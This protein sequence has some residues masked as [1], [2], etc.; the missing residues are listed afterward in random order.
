MITK[1]LQDAIESLKI[2]D[3]YLIELISEHKN[4]FNPKDADDLD[5]LEFQHMHVVEK[6]SVLETGNGELLLRVYTRLG[7][8]WI[9]AETDDGDASIKSI[10]ES[11]FISEYK[12]TS[13]IEQESIDEFCLKNSSFH[14]WPYWRELLNSQTCRMHLP[15]VT[16]ETVQFAQNRDIDKSHIERLQT[17]DG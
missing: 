4:S 13:P 15:R 9:D 3:V 11:Q 17:D 7:A 16:L 6:S 1:A 2:L 14:V 10:I 12:I 5:K 8:R